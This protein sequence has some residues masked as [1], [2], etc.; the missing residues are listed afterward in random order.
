MRNG[1]AVGTFQVFGLTGDATVNVLG[2]SRT[3]TATNGKFTDNFIPWDAHIYQ[4]AA[5]TGGA[6]F[7]PLDTVRHFPNPISLTSGNK[8][9]RFDTI[10]VQDVKIDIYNSGSTLIRTIYEKD[11]GNMGTSEWDLKD[12]N[13]ETVSAGI[14]YF[15]VEDAAGNKKKGKIALTK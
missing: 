10:A 4:L 2:E 15:V 13:G 5:G 6:G 1:A 12:S 8:K 9:A 14:Y 3:I 11:F 7:N